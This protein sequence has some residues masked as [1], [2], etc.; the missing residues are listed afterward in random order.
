MWLEV[1]SGEDAGR[2]VEVDRPLVLGRVSG[3]DLVIR[4]ARASRRHVELTPDDAGLRLRDLNSANGTLVDGQPARELELRGGEEI[5]IG[6]V[7]IAVLAD[8][9]PATGAPVAEPAATPPL[10]PERPSWSVVGRIVESRTQHGRRLTY[11]A[12]AVAAAAVAAVVLLAIGREA[13]FE[14]RAAR[15]V[16]DVAPSTV[17]IEARSGA[18]AR[19]GVGTAWVLDRDEGLIVTAAHVVNAGERF[20]AGRDEARVVGV[21]PCADLAVLRLPATAGAAELSLDDVA[22]ARQ[23]DTVIAFGFPEDAGGGERPASTRGVISAASTDFSDPAPDVPSYSGA[24]RMDAA[25]DPGFSGGPLVDLDGRLVGINAAVGGTEGG[26]TLLAAN[27][28]VNAERAAVVLEELRAG[29][30]LGW[31]GASFG[32]PTTAELADQGL[33]PGLWIRGIVPGS[34]ASRAGLRDGDYVAAVD[35]RPQDGT[36]SGWCATAG[37]LRGGGTAELELIRAGERRTATVRVA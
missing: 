7:R 6:R 9:P 26:R 24:I 34:A 3:S 21:N 11:A 37:G 13:S 27:Y 15:V 19:A 18:G 2:V 20:F 4:D 32:Y 35:G 16:R 25:L 12:L 14:D 31:I 28:A 23:G 1:L 30:S 36:M 8:E 10:E 33:P 22:P 5:R 29:R 17:R